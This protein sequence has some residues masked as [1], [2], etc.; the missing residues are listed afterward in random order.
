MDGNTFDATIKAFKSQRPFRPFTVT[1]VT[2][3]SWE[4]DHHDAI[5]VR[6]GVALY[7]MPGGIPVIFD[8]E[9][10]AQIVGDLAD[11]TKV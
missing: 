4:V 1:I 2:G 6:D 11:K 10:V 7:A 5:L 8:H 9:G 3:E